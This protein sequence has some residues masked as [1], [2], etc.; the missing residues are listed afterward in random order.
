PGEDDPHLKVLQA[1]HISDDEYF[2]HMVLDDLNLIIRDI[3]E[4]HKKDSESAPQTTVADELKENLEAVEN[5]KGS[6]DEKLV[7][8]YCKQL[9][10]NYKNLSESN[11]YVPRPASRPVTKFEQRGHR[12]GH[13]VWDL[14]FERVK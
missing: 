11:D 8:L 12:L 9:G 6:R 4:S 2:S 10:I 5:F 3:R 7:V 1:A 13:G 14:M